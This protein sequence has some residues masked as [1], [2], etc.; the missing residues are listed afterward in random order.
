MQ[1]VEQVT[2]CF[3]GT[4]NLKAQLETWAKED[5]RS[6]SSVMRDI[7]KRE[8]QRRTQAVALQIVSTSEKAPK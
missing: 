1:K 7:L 4:A 3:I 2:I 6:V 8:V 5:D